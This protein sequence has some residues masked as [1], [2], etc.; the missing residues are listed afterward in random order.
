MICSSGTITQNDTLVL[1]VSGRILMVNK[2]KN[3]SATEH[4]VSQSHDISFSY[5]LV[6]AASSQS[7]AFP[8]LFAI[9]C[10]RK[11]LPL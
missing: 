1:N 7:I 6:G 4:L 3:G 8:I 9:D 5:H 11:P 10:I 2:E